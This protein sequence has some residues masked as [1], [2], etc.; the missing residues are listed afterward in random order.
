MQ[1]VG[2]ADPHQGGNMNKLIVAEA[3]YIAGL[4]DGEG[5][6]SFAMTSH[7]RLIKKDRRTPLLGIANTNK[8]VLDWVL[9]KVGI[10]KV[11]KVS[12]K[13]SKEHWKDQYR[14]TLHGKQVGE[15][16]KQLLPYMIIKRQRAILVIEYSNT[17]LSIPTN[18]ALP[19]EVWDKRDR[20]VSDLLEYY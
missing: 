3:A 4:V 18:L 8:D 14:Y 20:I 5:W 2:F 15:L 16:L 13:F 19:K 11:F 17:I 12:R 7:K 1:G 10:G 9:F 6:V